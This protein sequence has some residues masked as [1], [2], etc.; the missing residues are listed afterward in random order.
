M[1]I[2]NDKKTVPRHHEDIQKDK[3]STD[4]GEFFQ[5]DQVDA[6]SRSVNNKK[7]SS[8]FNRT[9]P[10][11]LKLVN[12]VTQ[13]LQ[14]LG[15]FDFDD[16]DVI[17]SQMKFRALPEFQILKST[18][19]DLGCKIHGGIPYR[20]EKLGPS[21]NGQSKIT[22]QVE[23][24][25]RVFAISYNP[26]LDGNIKIF[27][28][29]TL[30][31][32]SLEDFVRGAVLNDKVNL[33]GEN[34]TKP[35]I[36][37]YLSRIGGGDGVSL[38]AMHWIHIYKR[39]G[40]DVSIL[41]GQKEQ[42]S[43]LEK[44][45]VSIKILDNASPDPKSPANQEIFNR[46]FNKRDETVLDE[47]IFPQ[48]E[49]IQKQLRDYI[50]KWNIDILHSEN[51]SL[52]WYH[53][54]M[55][56]ALADVVNDVKIPHVHRSHDFPFDRIA[57]H[58]QDM[59]PRIKAAV[60]KPFIRAASTSHICINSRDRDKY[61]PEGG[62]V[63]RIPNA[64]D[65]NDPRM[66]PLSPERK[67]LLKD[68]VLGKDHKEDFAGI[69]PVRPVGRKRLDVAIQFM[70]QL[71]TEGMPLSMVI[72]HDKKDA[73]LKELE[74]LQKAAPPVNLVYGYDQVAEYN[75][76]SKEPFDIWD[77]YKIADFALYFSDF[78]GYGNAL[79]EVLAMGLP[80]LVNE[81]EIYKLDI[82]YDRYHN[83]DGFKLDSIDIGEN[84]TF[85]DSLADPTGVF[86]KNPQAQQVK[87]QLQ[88][89]VVKISDLLNSKEGPGAPL[90]DNSPFKALAED[91]LKKL[92]EQNSYQAIQN[93][94][95][96]VMYR[97]LS[98]CNNHQD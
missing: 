74:A 20:P 58:W 33:N 60:L 6:T 78:E 55:G 85:E 77:Q 43:E 86:E 68:I 62:D 4:A 8:A 95:E 84:F 81:Y 88:K 79:L 48:A 83:L 15:N 38:E 37:F 3:T 22:L 50:K 14:Q 63:T 97:A 41:C 10:Q 73:S 71:Q 16:F 46:L 18:L 91:S 40:Y 56:L 19:T 93:Q 7:P 5:T 21:G 76:K 31:K 2:E 98:A 42:S 66:K 34:I 32:I 35:R 53:L 94:L 67:A 49:S 13:N 52:P 30:K 72:T 29:Q 11:I 65:I 92:E 89:L 1:K 9:S 80:T 17:A 82:G 51:F 27:D 25:D 44:L 75:A 26:A 96:P 24:D 23:L 64:I 61:F 28:K 87:E 45:G 39:S 57:Y 54:P 59:T 47:I 70:K 36:A 69:C 90:P 12:N